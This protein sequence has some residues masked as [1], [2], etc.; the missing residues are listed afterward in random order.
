M[1]PSHAD[2]IT[3]F[4]RGTLGCQCPDDVFR[5]IVITHQHTPDNGAPF[6]RLLVGDRLLIY[7][8]PASSTDATPETLAAL[9][10]NGRAERDAKGYNRFRLVIAS[11][12][13]LS[14]DPAARTTFESVLGR[15]DRAHLHFV[16]SAE[17]PIALGFP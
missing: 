4:V 11:Q 2:E 9:A 15:E 5:S 16:P 14:Q 3:R 6:T 13:A 17:I 8:L 12:D 1:D 10:R 7:L